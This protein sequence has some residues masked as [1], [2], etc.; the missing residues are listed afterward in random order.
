MLTY[1]QLGYLSCDTVIR[2]EVESDPQTAFD[3][4]ELSWE[5]VAAASDEDH[6][7]FAR[8][9]MARCAREC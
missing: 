1:F 3:F 7:E 8:G 5:I 9:C 6:S 4:D 2:I